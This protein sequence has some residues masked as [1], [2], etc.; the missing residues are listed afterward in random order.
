[1]FMVRWE[2]TGQNVSRLEPAGQFCPLYGEMLTD[3]TLLLNG[4]RFFGFDYDSYEFVSLA[5][6]MS[7]CSFPINMPMTNCS[8]LTNSGNANSN[9]SAGVIAA[10]IMKALPSHVYE[11]NFSR[12]RAL[13][14]ESHL[15]NT[16]RFTN[17]TFQLQFKINRDIGY[18]TTTPASQKA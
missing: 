11:L 10:D 2:G 16:G 3:I 8:T 14:G 4:Q 12:L 9:V 1:L 13:F 5:K 18:L 17:Q 15:Q 7:S 6:Q